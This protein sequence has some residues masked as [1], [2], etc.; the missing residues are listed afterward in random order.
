M[1]KE[2]NK[3]KKSIHY[4][5]KGEIKI[6]NKNKSQIHINQQNLYQY[7]QIDIQKITQTHQNF[8]T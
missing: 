8:K 1:K 6:K 2:N 4:A 7:E 3:T 5:Y